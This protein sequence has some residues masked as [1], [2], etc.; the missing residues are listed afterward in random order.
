MPRRAGPQQRLKQLKLSPRLFVHVYF[1]YF[2]AHR[3]KK[4]KHPRTYEYT[5]KAIGH[6]GPTF[7]TARGLLRLAALL[8][9]SNP[10]NP[11]ANLDTTGVAAAL[12]LGANS[13]ILTVY[14]IIL[15]D[16]SIIS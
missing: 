5:K 16:L 8:S 9:A 15:N 13:P 2:S 12:T 4:K 1:I 7:K 10:Y 11:N 14:H 3:D 6:F